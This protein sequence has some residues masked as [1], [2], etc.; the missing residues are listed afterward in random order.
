MTNDMYDVRACTKTGYLIISE[1]GNP[2][3]AVPI[4]RNIC[5]ANVY[6]RV[7]RGEDHNGRGEALLERI[8]SEISSF[9]ADPRNNRFLTVPLRGD[10]S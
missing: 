2:V 7:T 1:A 3:M 9:I 5:P 4:L 8:T 6:A 10:G